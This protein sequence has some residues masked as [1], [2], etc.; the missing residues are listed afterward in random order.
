MTKR[1]FA[2]EDGNLNTAT[3]ETSRLREYVDVD[4]SFAVK[5]TSG[6]IYKKNDAHP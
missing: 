5:P 2:Q 1:A 3:I 6:E 4:L